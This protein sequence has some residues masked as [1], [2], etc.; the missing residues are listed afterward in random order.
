MFNNWNAAK[1]KYKSQKLL[2]MFSKWNTKQKQ[3]EESKAKLN[4]ALNIKK[5]RKGPKK[6]AKRRL[7][8]GA[9]DGGTW[10]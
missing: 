10:G 3:A 4:Q 5:E 6:K 8:A 9:G 7:M 2:E 1:H